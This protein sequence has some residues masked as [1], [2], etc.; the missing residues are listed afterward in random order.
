[1]C[2]NSRLYVVELYNILYNDFL[3]VF[4]SVVHSYTYFFL[5]VSGDTNDAGRRGNDPA[6]VKVAKMAPVQRTLAT[7]SFFL[8]SSLLLFQSLLL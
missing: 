7:Y 4:L 3:P 8:P 6:E 5:L 2:N 1:M